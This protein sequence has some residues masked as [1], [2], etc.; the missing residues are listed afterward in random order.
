MKKI[1]QYSPHPPLDRNVNKIELK[2]VTKLFTPKTA[3]L[4]SKKTRNELSNNLS[5]V[6]N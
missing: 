1:G 2:V 5:I 4:K 3:I 6:F